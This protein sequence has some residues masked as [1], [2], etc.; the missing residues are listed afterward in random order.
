MLNE[1]VGLPIELL[2]T[3]SL[4][5]SLRICLVTAMQLHFISDSWRL[6]VTTKTCAEYIRAA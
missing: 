1:I 2:V 5:D 6:P 4:I 3:K